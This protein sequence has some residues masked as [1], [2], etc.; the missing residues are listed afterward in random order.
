PLATTVSLTSAAGAAV[1]G[2]DVTFTATV[3]P[4]VPG[5]GAVTFTIDGVS[6]SVPLDPLG[7]AH[8]TTAALHPGPHS[9]TAAYT[10]STGFLPSQSGPIAQ[11]VV[12]ADTQS[13]LTLRSIRI[14]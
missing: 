13:I 3:V 9:I 12:S 7:Q 6:I 10:G 8:L 5:I 11:D 2:Q 14:R 4:A 1:Y